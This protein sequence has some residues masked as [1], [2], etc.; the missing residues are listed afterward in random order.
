MQTF[1]SMGRACHLPE[2]S[3]DGAFTPLHLPEI[4]QYP[5]KGMWMGGQ[6]PRVPGLFSTVQAVAFWLTKTVILSPS[7]SPTCSD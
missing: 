6:G 7:E 3:D 5:E 2:G 4:P 1:I